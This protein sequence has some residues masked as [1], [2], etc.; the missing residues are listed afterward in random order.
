[1]AVSPKQDSKSHKKESTKK[2]DPSAR[3]MFKKFG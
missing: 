3:D 2:A 1:M